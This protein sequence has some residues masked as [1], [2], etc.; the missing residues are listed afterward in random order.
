MK[1]IRKSSKFF[2][3][4]GQLFRGGFNQRWIGGSE[5]TKVLQEIH[6]RHYGE[7]QWGSKVYQQTLHLGYY[8]PTLEAGATSFKRRC[9]A[10]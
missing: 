1:I 8:W 10:F 3:E 5:V 9:Q 2:V 7:H 6:A 4:E